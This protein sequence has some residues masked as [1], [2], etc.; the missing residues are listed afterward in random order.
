MFDALDSNK[1][2]E[3][4]LNFFL[5]LWF[6]VVWLSSEQAQSFQIEH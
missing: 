5:K 2:G 3:V 6:I 4:T 1:L